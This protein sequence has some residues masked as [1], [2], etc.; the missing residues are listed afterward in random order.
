MPFVA[1]AASIIA[2]ISAMRT[3]LTGDHLQ[4]LKEFVGKSRKLNGI[5][6]VCIEVD[7]PAEQLDTVLKADADII[8]LD[9]MNCEQ[10]RLAVGKRNKA[11]AGVL[12]EASGGITLENL[13]NIALTGV[14]RISVGAIT[15]G[16]KAVDIGLD[17]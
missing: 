12:L 14:D 10:Y 13:R 5:K 3:N 7:S 2:I 15:H 8:L 1:E 16:A 17:K 9:N 6:F 4:S 11:A